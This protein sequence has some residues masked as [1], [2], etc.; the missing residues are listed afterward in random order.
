VDRNLSDKDG[1]D[2]FDRFGMMNLF[3][4]G[5]GADGRMFFDDLNWTSAIPEP[6]T[7]VLLFC[8]GLACLSRRR[9]VG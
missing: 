8:G 4:A 2:T 3:I 1:L 5:N 6:S 9:R 7:L